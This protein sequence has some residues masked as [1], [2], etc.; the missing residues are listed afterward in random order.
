MVYPSYYE[1]FALPII[2]ALAC[3]CPV[4]C[5]ETL[6]AIAEWAVNRVI[7]TDVNDA[8]IFT[9]SLESFNS[10]KESNKQQ[11]MKNAAHVR[12]TF[13]LDQFIDSHIAVYG[14]I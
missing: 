2:E 14:T 3:G 1:G 5:D 11:A 7:A 12:E 4:L 6:P 10:S 9:E 8:E 13:G